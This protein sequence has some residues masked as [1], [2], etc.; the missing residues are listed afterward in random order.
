MA[1]DFHEIAFA[2]PLLAIALERIGRRPVA[3]CSHR[4]VSAVAGE[5]R[6]RSGRGSVRSGRRPAYSTMA[7][8]RRARRRRHRVHGACR[9]GAD[10]GVRRK[11]R[12]LLGL[13]RR[14]GSEPARQPL[15][16]IVRHPLC[17]AASGDDTRT[18]R[19]GCSSGCSAR[20]GSCRSGRRSCC[21]RCRCSPNGCCRD[22]PNHWTLTHQYTAP[23]VPI[24][25]LAA[26]DTVGKMSRGA[27]QSRRVD[28][29]G[30]HSAE[31]AQRALVGGRARYALGILVVAVWACGQMPFDQLTTTA[32]ESWHTTSYD[33]ASGP[34]LTSSRTGRRSRRATNSPHIWSIGPR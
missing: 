18:P 6:L 9:Q 12:L 21:S 25:T 1:A 29:T 27:L 13:L 26:V 14:T 28:G 20:S 5:G 3:H 24:L 16:H 33:Q 2:V 7:A 4:R 31:S 15:W 19:S 10:P 11:V 8:G 22:N 32:S 17:D 23:F 34:R 30:R